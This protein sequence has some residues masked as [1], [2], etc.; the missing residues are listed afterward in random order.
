MVT[1]IRP[2]QDQGSQYFHT[3]ERAGL[4]IPPILRRY[5]Q[6]MASGKGELLFFKDVG[7]AGFLCPNGCSTPKHIWKALNRFSELSGKKGKMSGA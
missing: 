1:C 3:D 2:T 7:S 4:W 6:L 5:C